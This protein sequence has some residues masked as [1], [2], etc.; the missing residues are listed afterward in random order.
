MKNDLN[1]ARRQNANV[2]CCMEYLASRIENAELPLLMTA[3]HY[4]FSS[5]QSNHI[6]TVAKRFTTASHTR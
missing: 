4:K 6:I 2:M 1:V 3:S 5:S